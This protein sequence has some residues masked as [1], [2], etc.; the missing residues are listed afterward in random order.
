MCALSTNEEAGT[1]KRPGLLTSANDP[2]G[3]HFEVTA[4]Q[5]HADE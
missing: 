1:L 4:E 5:A 2:S 3:L